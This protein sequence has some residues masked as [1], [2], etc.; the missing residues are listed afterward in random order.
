MSRK[1]SPEAHVRH[2]PMCEKHCRAH[3]TLQQN[4]FAGGRGKCNTAGVAGISACCG[5]AAVDSEKCR[6]LHMLH[7][8]GN[9]RHKAA[10]ICAG[11][12]KT[13]QL[14]LSRLGGAAAAGEVA[15]LAT[16]L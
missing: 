2:F 5:S 6:R 4:L 9:P 15:E 10:A 16:N 3:N 8:S 7:R 1:L 12:G 11:P 13:I 14:K